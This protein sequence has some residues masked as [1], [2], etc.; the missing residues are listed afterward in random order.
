M[1][2]VVGIPACAWLVVKDQLRHDTPARYPAA[3]LGGA[4]AVPILI[5]PMGEASLAVLDRIDGLLL[6]GSPSNVH[7]SH[8]DGGDSVTPDQHDLERDATTLR[9]IP[10]ALARG[11]PLLA[12]CRGI[13]EL[14][15]ALGGTLHQQVHGVADR[16]DHRP[17]PG[18]I[19]DKYAPR[20]LV[21]LSGQ[22]A[23]IVGSTKILVNSLHGQAIDVLAPGLV[24]E[25]RAP[26]N[27]I[28]AVRVEHARGF[29]FGVQWHPEW[30]YAND[31]AS[32]AL[33]RAFGE[34]CVAYRTHLRRAA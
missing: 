33:F 1:H 5:P 8:Y 4:N 7:P 17:G 10:E 30:D 23:H 27:T 28:E 18:T 11:M 15:V 25:G 19:E 14:N 32:L 13:Q 16:L 3:V 20:H 24:V 21:F 9:L 6:S 34:A 12:I 29:A 31:S 2:P 26:D 22:L